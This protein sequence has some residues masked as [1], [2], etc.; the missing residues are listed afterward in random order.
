MNKNEDALRP[1]FRVHAA[2]YPGFNRHCWWPERLIIIEFVRPLRAWAF[3]REKL[4][5]NLCLEKS[6]SLLYQSAAASDSIYQLRK[7]ESVSR[8]S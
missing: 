7:L 6:R 5:L 4:Q 1:V 3:R 8:I 2:S